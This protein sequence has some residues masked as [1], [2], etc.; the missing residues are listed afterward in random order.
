MVKRILSIC[1][2]V[3]A[4]VTSLVAS[5]LHHQN[6]EQP[7]TMYSESRQYENGVYYNTVELELDDLVVHN[8]ELHIEDK[9]VTTNIVSDIPVA[10]VFVANI[11]VN[12]QSIKLCNNRWDI[13]LNDDEIEL[14]ARILWVESRG[15]S[16]KGQR[17]VVEVILNRMNH[18]AF[19]GTAKEVLSMKG[20]FASWKSRN[21]AE[22]TEKEYDNIQ[23]V[24]DG[25]TE[26]TTLNTV[27]FSTN[28]R[29]KKLIEHIGGH[30]FCEYEFET[31]EEQNKN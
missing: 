2:I 10:G 24:L 4:S 9:A 17:A 30:Y 25:E 7:Y 27:Y 29:N 6:Q 26:I 31:R 28:Q 19:E 20:Q 23:K 12:K 1:L 3:I 5:R 22:P 11:E 15:E 8:D 14:I 13:E 18:W 16:N 21:T